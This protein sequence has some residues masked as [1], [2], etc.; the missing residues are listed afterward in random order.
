MVKAAGAWGARSQSTRATELPRRGDDGAALGVRGHAA[1]A[2]RMGRT[3]G[4]ARPRPRF[5]VREGGA[6]AAGPAQRR[7][8]AV[9]ASWRSRGTQRGAAT[10]RRRASETTHAG[11]EKQ[12]EWCG[13]WSAR[14]GVDAV[15]RDGDADEAA[16]PVRAGREDGGR[17]GEPGG[18]G[19]VVGDQEAAVTAQGEPSA[20]PG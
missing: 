6:R 18:A 9:G 1:T 16:E 4:S 19:V 3:L 2:P 7:G 17:A 11:D 10:P 20:T 12:R 15:V 13:R 14:D 5:V 8:G